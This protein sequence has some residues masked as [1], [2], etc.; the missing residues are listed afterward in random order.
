MEEII[1]NCLVANI[2]V[3]ASV[4]PVE[5]VSDTIEEVLDMCSNQ[6]ILIFMH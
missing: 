2:W 1:P 3:G 6:K 5:H 4:I